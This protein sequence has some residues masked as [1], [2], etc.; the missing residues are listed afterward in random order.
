M[1]KKILAPFEY[2][3]SRPI[4]P[5][6][7]YFIFRIVDHGCQC[8]F[9]KLL[10]CEHITIIC[11][12]WVYSYIKTVINIK[13]INDPSEALWLWRVHTKSLACGGR[14]LCRYTKT[15]WKPIVGCVLT[16]VEGVMVTVGVSYPSINEH[17]LNKMTVSSC[18][19]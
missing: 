10:S 13:H 17:V 14:D 4:M 8:I 11:S 3:Q 2:L 7:Y 18:L 1:K 5:V 16:H 12:I 15:Y 19:S 9:N 6:C